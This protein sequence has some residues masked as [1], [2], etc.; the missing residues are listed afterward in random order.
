MGK[1]YL[2]KYLQ[3]LA[4]LSAIVLVADAQPGERK[5]G[6]RPSQLYRVSV[7]DKS[8]GSRVGFIDKTGKLV[9]SFD[10]LPSTALG[11]ADFHEGRARFWLKRAKGTAG[12]DYAMG[13]IDETGKVI[14][15]PSFDAANDFSDGLAY[16]E[17]KGARGFINRQGKMVIKLNRL[18]VADLSVTHF[19]EGMAA[20]QNKVGTWGYIDRSGSLAIKP[21][22]W[23]ADDFSEGVAWVITSDRKKIGW[24][25]KSGQWAVTAVNGQPFSESE[26]G[27][28]ASR[29]DT[30][31]SMK[32]SEGLAPFLV[33]VYPGSYSR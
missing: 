16:V 22:Y 14:I 28:I 10:Q 15:E 12:V 9:I 3:L 29:R 33:I 25:D 2:R 23:F 4:W 24:I 18:E 19:H 31:F 11:V 13:Y 8:G 17:T 26:S 5:E 1:T 32:F 30:S 21:R 20:A 7:D 6:E 27:L